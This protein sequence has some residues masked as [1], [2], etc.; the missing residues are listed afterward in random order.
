ME[1]KLNENCYHSQCS[2]IEFDIR[3]CGD[4]NPYH[5]ELI[6]GFQLLMDEALFIEVG[7]DDMPARLLPHLSNLITFIILLMRY[8]LRSKQMR[9]Y[10]RFEQM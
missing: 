9:Y 7:G 6:K 2:L 5:D 10:F 4:V 8:Y 1:T 3:Y